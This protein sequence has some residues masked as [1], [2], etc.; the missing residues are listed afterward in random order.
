MRVQI[1]G[2]CRFSYLGLRGFQ[3]E[4]GSLEDRRAFLYDP[5]R[6]AR[7]WFWF[8]NVTLPALRAQTDPDFTLVVM[9]GPDL[10]EPFLTRLRE[11]EAAIPQLRLSLVQP[12]NYHL[13][14][15]DHAV[16][17]FRE[18]G[19]E[20]IGHFRMDDDDAVA[21]DFV[22]RARRDFRLVEVACAQH[23]G[24]A[25]DYMR[26][27]LLTASPRGLKVTPRIFHHASAALVVYL[28]PE[29]MRT[30]VHLPHWRIAEHVPTLGL[31]DAPM[32][33]RLLT[34]DNDSGAEGPG[35]DW[36]TAEDKVAM[37]WDRFRLRRWA[38]H[39]E[40]KALPGGAAA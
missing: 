11:A 8:E 12:M 28:P 5:G 29:D 24:A 6:L 17:P 18:A 1:L 35:H 13:A 32:F 30:A 38:L 33:C 23:D 10:P 9:T 39:R 15:C 4:H 36:E 7:R 40:A 34:G 37:M 26:G 20:V 22:E 25:I 14:A 19:A 3:V 16:R 31:A 27:L 2:L 21:V